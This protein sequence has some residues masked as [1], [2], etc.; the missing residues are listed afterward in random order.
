[1]ALTKDSSYDS[2]KYI[3][4]AP[5]YGEKGTAFTR[6]FRPDFEGGLHGQVDEFASLHEHLLQTDP[7]ATPGGV[8]VA[9]P[10]GGAGLGQAGIAM[11]ARSQQAYL[12]RRRKLFGF[13]RRHVEDDAIRE[14][15]DANAP[16]DGVAA[17]A[18]VITY[19]TDPQTALF[20]NVQDDEWSSASIFWIGIDI[21]SPRNWKALLDRINRERPAAD[22]KS[23][24]QLLRRFL[25]GF[26]FPPS[27]KSK[28]EDQLQD[29]T[30]LDAG[31]NPSIGVAVTKLS[32]LWKKRIQDREIT[33]APP[34]LP[35]SRGPRTNRVDA[36]YSVSQA[37]MLQHY[38]SLQLQ[39]AE[40]QLATGCSL[41]NPM[42]YAL[43][44][45]LKVFDAERHCW[46]CGGFGHRFKDAE[47]NVI[48]PSPVLKRP[49]SAII[50]KLESV[51]KR[52]NARKP[53]VRK[54]KF[55]RRPPQP[56]SQ[57]AESESEQVIEVDE[58]M[59]C[60]DSQGN[61]CGTITEGDE[62]VPSEPV[63]DTQPAS[64]QQIQ[65][66][67]S[68]H[69]SAASAES[70]VVAA[71]GEA[72]P[73]TSPPLPSPPVVTQANQ[74]DDASPPFVD[75]DF[76]DGFSSSANLAG[77][78]MPPHVKPLYKTR[79]IVTA[80]VVGTA[81]AVGAFARSRACR[82]LLTSCLLGV[83][84]SVPM[85]TP[86]CSFDTAH[87]S[88]GLID[89]C[90]SDVKVLNTSNHGTMDTGATTHTSGRKKLFPKKGVEQYNPNI[91]VQVANGVLC[92]VV[93]K[94]TMLIPVVGGTNITS[95]KKTFKCALALSNALLVQD[96]PVTL[97]SPKAMFTNEGI[98]TYF[99][100]SLFFRTPS[101][102]IF[103]FVETE[104][105]Y[106]LPLLED[107]FLD[108]IDTSKYLALSAIPSDVISSRF[109]HF[110][111][112]RIK[113]S[114]LDVTGVDISHIT[115]THTPPTAGARRHSTKIRTA[116]LHHHFGSCVASDTCEFEVST[117][118]GFQYMITFLDMATRYLA[119][120]FMRT[121]S[122]DEVRHCYNQ[123]HTD[124]SRFMKHGRVEQ[125]F[126]DN[127]GEF[128][129]PKFFATTDMDK[130]CSQYWIRRRFIVPW[131]PQ[132][133]PAESSNR[134]LLRPIRLSLAVASFK[135]QTF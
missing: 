26:T 15:I 98:R 34:K 99:N 81:V 28:C 11:V 32:E 4:C 1:M 88:F 87:V 7:G 83:A 80:A 52:E 86:T 130:W 114:E 10:G 61:L 69:A 9:H 64:V 23:P 35:N 131:N 82:A 116:P 19:G 48:C 44:S 3:I 89:T 115:K 109:M 16:G 124:H 43:S 30:W 8:L 106:V 31:G 53:N 128:G 135:Q 122:A 77:S 60:F 76:Y 78:V 74:P 126:M 13:I 95:A 14:D 41:P 36:H 72:L 102:Y 33:E 127:G 54:M 84:A 38:S 42:P 25:S 63:S 125:W 29:C 62:F 117:P 90:I 118:F 27:I 100:D 71:T 49:L 47:G 5:W 132:E 120:Y 104:T 56:Q 20:S 67:M 46:N 91:K 66:S 59:N 133:N 123:Y 94:G 58:S 2:S 68:A 65:Q 37:N 85:Q 22:R 75:D 96:F 51:N 108:T 24:A 134:I 39:N 110:S 113:M 107:T 79:V 55:V 129:A 18:I 121:H 17:W 45:D 92:P 21:N 6:V 111:L 105:L 50:K 119:V 12:T 57:L 103:Q 101:G 93:L 97:I 112:D 70:V 73:P 40:M